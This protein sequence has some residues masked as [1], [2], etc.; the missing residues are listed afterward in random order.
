ARSRIRP[1]A[2]ASQNAVVPPLPSTTS[3]PS[4]REKS[5]RNPARIRPTSERTG[6]CRCEV[7][8]SDA[9]VLA[10]AASCSGRTFD[11]PH[12]NRPSAGLRSAGML[13]CGVVVIPETLRR[14]SDTGDALVGLDVAPPGFR[15]DPRGDDR[16]GWFAVP[17]GTDRP[18]PDE[19][20]VQRVLF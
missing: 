13:S 18:V 16:S 14:P 9:P 5:S 17:S 2:A 1:R 11:G 15:D 4:G 12:P 3:Y 20:L 7:P 19:L 6:A 8:I 10:S